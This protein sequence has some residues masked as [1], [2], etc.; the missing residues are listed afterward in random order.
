METLTNPNLFGPAPAGKGNRSTFFGAVFA[1]LL[2]L[3]LA[4][5]LYFSHLTD[6]S[7]PQVAPT[8]G[9]EN[10]RTGQDAGVNQPVAGPS[11][12][13]TANLASHAMFAPLLQQQANATPLIFR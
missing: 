1:G 2:V 6:F 8:G 3:F 12:G 13:T 7:S 4:G 9:V 10:P 5:M 11:F